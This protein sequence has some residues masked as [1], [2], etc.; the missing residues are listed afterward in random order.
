MT[1]ISQT[2]LAWKHRR[3]THLKLSVTMQRCPRCSNVRM[4]RTM[5]FLSPGSADASFCRICA[6]LRPATYLVA[7]GSGQSL[8][9]CLAP[10]H[11]THSH[12]LLAANHL[13]GDLCAE[14][15]VV[16][17]LDDLGLDDSREHALAE[18]GRDL[19]P[20]S[21]EELAG[22]DAVVPFGVVVRVDERGDLERGDDRHRSDETV[23]RA[24]LLL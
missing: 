9:T 18:I 23:A 13:D 3:A 6:S 16:E 20:A 10:G 14:L 15:F 7:C 12:R 1:P 17:R 21:I 4:K 11:T 19:I 2:S 22:S 8:S 5:C 24:A